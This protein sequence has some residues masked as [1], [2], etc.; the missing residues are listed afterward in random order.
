MTTMWQNWV[1]NIMAAMGKIT[2]TKPQSQCPGPQHRTM[3]MSPGEPHTSFEG[4][5]LISM[6]L[7]IIY[8]ESN[9]CAVARETLEAAQASG[10][11]LRCTYL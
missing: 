11:M 10:N 9:N 5:L 2:S 3:H 8:R 7:A 4:A 6:Y 1:V